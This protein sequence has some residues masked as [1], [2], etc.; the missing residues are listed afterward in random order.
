MFME[1]CDYDEKNEYKDVID[2]RNDE[3]G[4]IWLNE[5]EMDLFY[6]C[7][8]SRRGISKDAYQIDRRTEQKFPY[9]WKHILFILAFIHDSCCI[10]LCFCLNLVL[11]F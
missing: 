1:A 5:V 3:I 4:G 6:K 11:A 10:N 7:T 8:I 9:N 2:C